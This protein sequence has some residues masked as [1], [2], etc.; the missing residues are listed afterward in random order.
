MGGKRL[1]SPVVGMAPTPDG[2]GYWLVASDG[3]IF[4]SA[5]PGSTGP[6]AAD[7]S[8]SPSSA[9]ASGPDDH[10]YWLVASDGGV[11]SF[12]DV[13][14]HGSMGGRH[15]AAP[16]VSIETIPGAGGY[17]E[18]AVR[19]RDIRLRRAV[20]R[21]DGWKAAGRSGR[22]GGCTRTRA[23][24]R[25][26]GG[27]EGRWRVRLRAGAIPG[28]G[29]PAEAVGPGRRHDRGKLR[30]PGK[31]TQEVDRLRETPG[32][33]GRVPPAICQAT[34]SVVRRRCQ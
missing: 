21:L 32:L 6:W 17:W 5:T 19:R 30:P 20:L 9:M 14:F 28:I 8:P 22:G 31:P 33:V 13:V 10:G 1:N 11:F 29:G 25:L 34:A 3:G 26:L 27:G 12:G 4:A 2:R 16:I 15:L 18:I 7:R 24:R 23:R